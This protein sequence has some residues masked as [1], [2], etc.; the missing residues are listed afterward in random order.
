MNSVNPNVIRTNISTG[1]FYD[2][3]EEQNLLTPI[4]G[5]VDVFEKLLGSND[6]SGECF[7]IGPRYKEQG[8]VP[9]KGAEYLDKDSEKV[10]E[11]LYRRAHP[12]HQP[13]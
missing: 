7:E 12:L 3:L 9:K 4:E 11:L 8:A 13:R 10:C 5:V 1:T 6:A 2:S